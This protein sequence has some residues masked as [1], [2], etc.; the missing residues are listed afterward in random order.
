MTSYETQKCE[1]LEMKT[2]QRI[3]LVRGS[4]SGQVKTS[5]CHRKGEGGGGGGDYSTHQTDIDG[6]FHSQ[7]FSL[8]SRK[9]FATSLQQTLHGPCAKPG[10]PSSEN[11]AKLEES[12]RK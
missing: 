4:E 5:P 2:T 3:I 11:A 7:I 10:E 12:P 8:I 1:V 9:P 6:G